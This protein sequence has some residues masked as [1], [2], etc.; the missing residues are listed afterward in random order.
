MHAGDSIDRAAGEAVHLDVND[1]ITGN[2]RGHRRA[3]P[4]HDLHTQS[5]TFPGAVPGSKT[6]QDSVGPMY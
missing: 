1:N 2:L 6:E 3:D 4:C 5:T